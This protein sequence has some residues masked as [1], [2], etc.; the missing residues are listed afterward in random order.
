MN[1]NGTAAAVAVAD[2]FRVAFEVA[3][4]SLQSAVGKCMQ[5]TVLSRLTAPF[6]FSLITSV[7]CA[8][9]NFRFPQ[10][11]ISDFMFLFSVFSFSGARPF[12]S[13]AQSHRMGPWAKNPLFVL[14][15]LSF[16]QN[17]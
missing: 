11:Q 8:S 9:H 6:F 3:V 12:N 17:L 1:T 14:F 10:F 5:V 16:G 2:A 13:V 15:S 7:A 4:C